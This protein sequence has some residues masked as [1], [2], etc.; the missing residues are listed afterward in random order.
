MN[1]I[2]KGTFV[3][4]FGLNAVLTS[5]PMK[6]EIMDE[7][8]THLLWASR[9]DREQQQAAYEKR[10]DTDTKFQIVLADS[11]TLAVLSA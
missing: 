6:V 11:G 7:T 10:E 5:N 1:P 8:Q 9:A 4:I 2:L 3:M